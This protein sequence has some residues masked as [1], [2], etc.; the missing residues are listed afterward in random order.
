MRASLAVLDSIPMLLPL[1]GD[2][3]AAIQ[4]AEKQQSKFEDPDLTE[5]ERTYIARGL[6]RAFE[7]LRELEGKAERDPDGALVYSRGMGDPK[8]WTQDRA[9]KLDDIAPF[10]AANIAAWREAEAWQPPVTS[11]AQAA[12]E[13]KDSPRKSNPPNLLNGPA[14]PLT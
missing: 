8:P 5:E 3:P 14:L 4:W 11:H 12:A 2:V 7:Q 10:S 1:T 6:L 13:K 9:R